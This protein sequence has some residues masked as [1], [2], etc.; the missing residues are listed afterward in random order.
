M[1]VHA[2]IADAFVKEGVETVFG[3][4]GN[5]NLEWWLDLVEAGVEVIHTRQETPAVSMAEGWAR[6]TGKVGVATTTRGPGLTQSATALTV[7]TKQKVPI[8]VYAGDSPQGDQT[9]GQYLD[10]KPFILA[11]GAG[12]VGLETAQDAQ[13]VVRD[14]FFQARTERRPIVLDVPMDLVKK[15][16]DDEPL[17]Y[18]PSS[19]LLNQAQPIVPSAE[20]LGA[21]VEMIA[22]SER[23]VIIA[24]I[25]AAHG[26]AED[27]IL[28]LGERIGALL[29][30]TL[31]MKG[32][33]ESEWNAGI[34]GLFSTKAAGELFSEADLVI[35]VGASMDQRTI[36]GGYSFAGARYLHIDNR[37]TYRMGND[38]VADCYLQGDGRATVELLAAALAADGFEQVGYRTDEVRARLAVDPDPREFEIAEGTVDPRRAATLLDELLPRE[39]G[40]VSGMAHTTGLTA[41]SMPKP[42]PLQLWTTGFIAVGQVIPT[43]IGVATA[44]RPERVA[45]IEG[46]IG[47]MM[48]VNELDTAARLGLNLLVVVMNDEALGT[49]YQHM[50]A[51]HL[52]TSTVEIP[53]PDLA[54]VGRALGTRGRLARTLDDVRAGVEEFLAGDGPYVLDI[55]V[56]RIPSVAYRRLQYGMDD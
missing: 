10:Q 16:F 12:Y 34:A 42:R 38:R 47:V 17:D 32:R 48:H 8:V 30:S 29:A 39:I 20:K 53:C 33:P 24:G 56:S 55:R 44:V 31:P 35:G 49:E 1:K 13:D 43:A 14:A 22:A 50:T 11:T 26:G 28:A 18:V 25:G 51:H 54:V 6:T 2:A 21:A 40:L 15:D 23:P 41:L 9:H 4:M 19:V 52:P 45:M 27:A 5:A 46:D 37:P 36:E 3:V 7:A